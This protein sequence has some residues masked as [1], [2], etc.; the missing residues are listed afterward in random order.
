MNQIEE[1]Q[2]LGYV[3]TARLLRVSE[4]TLERW[5]RERRI[6]FVQFPK[7]GARAGVRFVRTHVLKWLEQQTVRPTRG[8]VGATKVV[9][10][11]EN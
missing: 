6:P 2:V 1:E 10:V 9:A 8:R 11:E 7:R 5:V 4:R 3:E